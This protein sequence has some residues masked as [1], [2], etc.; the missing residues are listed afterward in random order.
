VALGVQET[1]EKNKPNGSITCGADQ[2]APLNVSARP[3]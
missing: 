2:A 3:E 1:D